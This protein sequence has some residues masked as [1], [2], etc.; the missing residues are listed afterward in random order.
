[1]LVMVH[2]TNKTLCGDTPRTV[3]NVKNGIGSLTFNNDALT[4]TVERATLTPASAHSR[5]LVRHDLTYR[6]MPSFFCK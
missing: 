4:T 6:S 5:L 2:D 3:R 1:M